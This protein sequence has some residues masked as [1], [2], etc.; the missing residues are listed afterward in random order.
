MNPRLTDCEEDALTTSHRAGGVVD[1][2][3]DYR[4]QL[5]RGIPFFVM[6]LF[7]PGVSNLRLRRQMQFFCSSTVVWEKCIAMHR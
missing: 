3:Y 4:N 2:L 5:F 1:R 6:A 7:S